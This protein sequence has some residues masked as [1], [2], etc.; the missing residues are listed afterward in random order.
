MKKIIYIILGLGLG[1]I[2]L[3]SFYGCTKA[4]VIPVYYIPQDLKDCLVFKSGSYWIYKYENNNSIDSCYVTDGPNFSNSIQGYNRADYYNEQC[5]MT[6][7]GSFLNSLSIN[8]TTFSLYV[9]NTL[10]SGSEATTFNLGQIYSTGNKDTLENVD[11]FDTI[12][13][14]KIYYHDVFVTQYKSK[15][16]KGVPYRSTAYF[17]KNI[18]LVKFHYQ[19][20]TASLTWNLLR[21]KVIQ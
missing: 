6:Y 8:L 20:G 9:N 3:H 15:T 19:Q 16:A 21:Y 14:N 11:V 4:K 2:C 7:D 13:I 18:G 17:I 5:T 1:L 10:F 12:T